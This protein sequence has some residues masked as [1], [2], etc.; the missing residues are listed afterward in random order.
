MA[1][2][3]TLIVVI[4][5]FCPV[6]VASNHSALETQRKMFIEAEQAIGKGHYTTYKKLRKE[7]SNYPL[8]PYIEYKY[9]LRRL[10]K[11]TTEEILT[12]VNQYA[13]TPLA[14]RLRFRWLKTLAKRGRTQ[15]LIANYRPT[16]NTALECHYRSALLKT[17][18]QNQ[19]LKGIQ[20]LW[21]VGNS[22][23]SACDP[24]FNAWKKT[25]GLTT[26][27]IWQRIR[28]AMN[29]G[30]TGLA[31]YLAR[32]LSAEERKWLRL[33]KKVRRTPSLVLKSELFQASNGVHRSILA[34]G[35]RRLAFRDIDKA[36]TVWEEINDTY[37]FS[38]EELTTVNRTIALL[39]AQ[40]RRPEA[41]AWLT[42]VDPE[43]ENQRIREWRV[44]AAIYE[45][46]WPSALAAI[47]WL[48]EDE[49]QT[50]RWKYWSGRAMESLGFPDEA[51][52]VYSQLAQQ[53][54]YHGFLAADRLGQPYA[55]ENEPLDFTR[56]DLATLETLPAMVRVRELYN[57]KR[58]TDARR[59]WEYLSKH[60]T[61]D[62]LLRAAK[63]AQTWGWHSRAIFAAARVE[64]WNDVPLRFPLG[65]H[66][67]VLNQATEF[68]LEPAWIYGVMRQESAFVTDARSGKGALGLMQLLP[69]TG[70][71]VAVRYN[72][73]FKNK[74]D[75]L[76]ADTNIRLGS[77]YLRDV[78]NRLFDNPVLATAAYNAGQR[79]VRSWLPEARTV[80]A[81]AWIESIPY[82]E[83]RDYLERVMAYTVIYDWRLTKNNA[84][85]LKKYMLPIFSPQEILSHN[86]KTGNKTR[87]DAS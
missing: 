85:S 79:R 69:T 14:D 16:L 51:R 60:L 74:A 25:G 10:S 81:D 36:L 8:L 4:F 23:P 67:T 22:Q 43:Q 11:A 78:R 39:L 2:I 21:L 87:R 34:Y 45:E 66:Q 53:R 56:E 35:V 20:K 5:C 1:R 42:S 55:F 37:S 13:D 17:N 52:R 40:K 84:I 59:E 9:L 82:D 50:T 70:K 47:E 38:L 44:R 71:D 64:Y 29:K 65:Y 80:N 27:L 15:E 58:L 33:W 28:L 30:Q 24:V 32:S 18:Q 75:L 6:A 7:L 26:D 86:N 49:R 48:S 63:L 46:D 68:K 72:T 19:A 73:P 77:A 83:T 12:F 57:L 3:T 76:V 62:Q 54:D 31:D 41:L 61:T